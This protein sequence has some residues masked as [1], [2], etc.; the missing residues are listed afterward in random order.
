MIENIVKYQGNF[1]SISSTATVYSRE[2]AKNHS[3]PRKFIPM[4]WWMNFAVRLNH[5][6]F[7]QQKFLPLK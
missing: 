4:K 1:L 2:N 3:N 5:E 7:F 6:T